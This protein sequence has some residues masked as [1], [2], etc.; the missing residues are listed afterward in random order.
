MLQNGPNQ[1]DSE[2]GQLQAQLLRVDDQELDKCWEL[3]G[4]IAASFFSGSAYPLQH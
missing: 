1:A 2:R 3:A 4:K